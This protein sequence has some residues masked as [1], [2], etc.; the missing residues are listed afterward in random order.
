MNG[1]LRESVL[2]GLPRG[3]GPDHDRNAAHRLMTG[4]EHYAR[5]HFD[6]VVHEHK[7]IA[8]AI[9]EGDGRR[10][11]PRCEA[12]WRIPDAG[13]KASARPRPAIPVSDPG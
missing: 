5:D 13:S 7:S 3:P 2:L 8:A 10:L 6:Q 11:L 12:I 1:R 9:A 4:V